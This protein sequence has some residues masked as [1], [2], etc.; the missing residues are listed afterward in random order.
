MVKV[1]DIFWEAEVQGVASAQEAASDLESSYEGVKDSAIASA[2]AQETAADATEENTEAVEKNERWSNRLKVATGLL[3]SALFFVG[4]SFGIAG[5]AATAYAGATA[6][7]ALATQ[8]A[9]G[10]IATL[11]GVLAGPAGLA[12]AV[13][14][15]TI[16]VG[17]L[18]AELLGLSD[19]TPVVESETA[20]I[21]GLFADMAF[22]IGG[23]LVGFIAAAFYGLTGDFQAAKNI[24]INTSVEW[25]KAVTRFGARVQ[26]GFKTMYNAV[27]GGTMQFFEFLDYTWRKGFNGLLT[28]T[29]KV[30][31]DIS[32][33]IVGGFEAA[34]ST[35]IGPLNDLIAKVN[36]IPKVDIEPVEQPDF[37]TASPLDVGAGT[38]DNESLDSRMSGVNQRIQERQQTA[39]ELARQQLEQ[40]A[41]GTIGPDRRTTTGFGRRA[42]LP[43]EDAD[44]V[45][46]RNRQ[47]RQRQQRQTRQGRGLRRRAESM[48]DRPTTT[49]TTED[50]PVQQDIN[51]EIGDQSVDLSNLS[52]QERKELASLIGD[53]LGG[54]TGNL[55]G[56]R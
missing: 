7:A 45:A 56:V 18:G 22:T 25:I 14:L 48:P 6:G 51:V 23:P 37:G 47:R 4:S 43:G 9:S 46:R 21:T 13:A 12:G 36:D 42:F 27:R 33:A 20:T 44:A 11:Y 19:V 53:E 54:Q 41:P 31:N 24:F 55:S 49:A 10:A 17:L 8:V 52:R 3:S 15:A 2:S 1:G 29:Q 40:F 30:V 50:K 16:G 38:V 32:N 35:A 26:L 5:T 34:I 39:N 28:T